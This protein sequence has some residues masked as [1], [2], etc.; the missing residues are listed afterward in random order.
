MQIVAAIQKLGFIHEL[1]RKHATGSPEQL[2]RKLEVSARQVYRIINEM[3]DLGLPIIY[4]HKK[5][6]YVY[7]EEV[8]FHIELKV[9]KYQLIQDKKSD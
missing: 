5:S 6:S 3:K 1:I 9:G 8:Y 4:L 2:A 7:E